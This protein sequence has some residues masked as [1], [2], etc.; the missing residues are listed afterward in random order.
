MFTTKFNK[1][2]IKK[3]GL[4]KVCLLVIS[5]TSLSQNQALFFAVNDYSN[6]FEFNNL[7]TPIGDAETIAKELEDMYG[8]ETAVYRNP[9][10]EKILSVLEFWQQKIFKKD[11]QLFVYFSGHGTFWDLASKGFFVPYGSQTGYSNYIDLTTLGNIITK[12]KSEHILLAIDACYWGATDQEIVFRGPGF[13]RPNENDQTKR[14]KIV[15]LQL[16]NNS[17]LLITSG[18]QEYTSDEGDHSPFARVILSGLRTA[19]TS[20]DGLFLFS[21]LEAQLER[22]SPRP[23]KGVLEGHQDGG[24][25]FRSDTIGIV[26]SYENQLEQPRDFHDKEIELNTSSISSFSDRDGNSY[27]YRRLKDGKLWMTKNL[28]LEIEGSY[29]YIGFSKYCDEYGRLYNWDAANNG[30]AQLGNGWRLPSYDEWREMAKHYGG[31]D[32]DAN[33]YGEAA[34]ADLM[35]GGFSYFSA[36]LGGYRSSSGDFYDLKRSGLYWSS[37]DSSFEHAW[38]FFFKGD[39]RRLLWGGYLKSIARSV[40]CIKD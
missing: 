25:V 11:E 15:S 24:F 17:R 23:H 40:R 12:I 16:R 14:D 32:S 10:L 20:G 39:N 27:T 31:A 28:N 2:M 35:D 18:G 1:N 33:D 5:T 37:S 34:Y 30:C 22:V 21:D 26:P 13:R 36:L 38:S 6:N 3:C 4:L 9:S 7:R 8:F 29:C 19:Y